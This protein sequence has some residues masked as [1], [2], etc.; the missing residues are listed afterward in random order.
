MGANT[1][2]SRLDF[3]ATEKLNE[4]LGAQTLPGVESTDEGKIL[5]VD[6]EGNWAVSD[7]ELPAVTSEDAGK[8][9]IVDETGKWQAVTPSEAGFVMETPSDPEV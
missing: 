2:Y 3:I 5:A 4:I 9:L 1:E 7:P 8:I 6:E